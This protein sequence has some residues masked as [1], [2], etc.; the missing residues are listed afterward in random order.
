MTRT[1]L[2]EEVCPPLSCRASS[3][4]ASSYDSLPAALP[5]A[6]DSFSRSSSSPDSM[7]NLGFTG[8]TSRLATKPTTST[9]TMMY[10]ES[11]YRSAPVRPAAIW[12]AGLLLGG[13]SPGFGLPTLRGKA[14]HERADH[15]RDQIN[16]AQRQE[17]GHDRIHRVAGVGFEQ[18]ARER[19]GDQRAAPKAHDSEAGGQARPVREP[20]D[21]RRDRRDVAD[22]EPDAAHY[23]ASQIH[24]P[25]LRRR[26]PE[27]PDGE[28]ARPAQGGGEHRRARPGAFHP[29]AEHCGR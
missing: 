19:R 16:S 1:M 22:A 15:H 25:Q 20:L 14:H 28:P 5:E 12:V 24:Q 9:P 13:G 17:G 8:L 23:P 2:E 7:W 4:M 10:R 26:H 21:Q 11:V 3:L 18:R 29:R 6:V 27:C